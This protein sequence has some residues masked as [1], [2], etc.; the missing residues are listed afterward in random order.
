MVQ[1]KHHSLSFEEFLELYPES[2]RQY[3]LIRGEVIE[4]RPVGR[5]EQISGFLSGKLFVQIENNALPYFVPKTCVIKPEREQ[6]G[7][8]PDV[9]VV[10]IEQISKEPLWEKSSAILNGQSVKLAIEVVSTNWRVDYGIK[11]NDYEE[12]GIAEYWIVDYN[13]LGAVRHIGS[14]KQPT[15]TVCTLIDGEYQLAQFREG[16]AVMSPTFPG[17]QLQTHQIFQ[18]L[19]SF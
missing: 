5:H 9:A 12:M 16:E 4:L 10:D 7:Y 15:V 2:G 11:L 6:S 3:E 8:V 19:S 1:A 14:P 13:A 17:L 18:A